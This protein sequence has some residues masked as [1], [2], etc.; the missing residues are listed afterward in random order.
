MEPPQDPRT[1]QARPGGPSPVWPE[2][3]GPA[4]LPARCRLRVSLPNTG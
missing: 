2:A 3:A 1:G 4:S